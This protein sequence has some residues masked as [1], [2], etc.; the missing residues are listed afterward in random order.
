M[1][2]LLPDTHYQPECVL[3]F[4]KLAKIL[5]CQPSLHTLASPTMPTLSP[6][7]AKECNFINSAC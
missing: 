6:K 4:P 7:L 3:I 1:I 2:D 5:K